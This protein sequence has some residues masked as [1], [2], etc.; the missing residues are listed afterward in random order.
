MKLWQHKD[1]NEVIWTDK[2]PSHAWD[3]ITFMY[4]DELPEDMSDE[5]WDWWYDNSSVID[6]VRMGPKI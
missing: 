5:V 6:G 2:R 1:T 3:E 4:E